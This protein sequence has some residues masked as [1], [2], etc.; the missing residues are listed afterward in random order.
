MFNFIIG[1]PKNK[2]IWFYVR[3]FFLMVIP[4]IGLFFTLYLAFL[5]DRDEDINKLAKG[6]LIIRILAVIL[7][8][9]LLAMGV[10]YIKPNIGK[11]L[12]SSMALIKMF[13]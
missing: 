2:T 4:G 11:W 7:V 10:Y 1:D 6:A 3:I 12:N 8:L 13:R 5:E 9:V